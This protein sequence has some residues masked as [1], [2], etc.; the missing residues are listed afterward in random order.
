MEVKVKQL[1]RLYRKIPSFECK[2]GCTDCCGPVP[3]KKAE[4]GRVEDKRYGGDDLICPYAVGGR[5]EIYDVRPFMC[6]LFGTVDDYRLRCPHGC[7]PDVL[8]SAEKG[9]ELMNR[10]RG[11]R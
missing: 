9:R 11:I 4:W 3:F 10:Y 5:C 6:R 8:M 7:G 1:I 2:E